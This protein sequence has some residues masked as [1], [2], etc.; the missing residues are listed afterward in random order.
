MKELTRSASEKLRSPS[1]NVIAAATENL[2]RSL[3]YTLRPGRLWI[4]V[5]IHSQYS[6]TKY[7]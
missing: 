1:T 3:K 7:L 5:T 6:V 4:E 2:G